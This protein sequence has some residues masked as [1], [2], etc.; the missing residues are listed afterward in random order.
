VS[1]VQ[2]L[3]FSLF[4]VNYP[5]NFAQR[6]ECSIYRK[7]SWPDRLTAGGGCIPQA[8]NYPLGLPCHRFLV[9]LKAAD[10]SIR[11]NLVDC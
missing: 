5:R 10:F 11:S 4:K 9:N 7:V 6:S 2:C 3:H 8:H 1:G